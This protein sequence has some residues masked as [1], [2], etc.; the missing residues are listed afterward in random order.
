M[1]QRI[2]R[3]IELLGLDIAVYYAGHHSGHVLT[4]EQGHADSHIWAD[5]INVGME[6]GA[7]D[8]A[9]LAEY[10]RGLADGG[11]ARSGHRTPT[12]VVEAPVHGTDEMNVR[13]N[14]WQFRQILGRGVHGVLLCQTESAGAVRAF[15]EACR[16]PIHL[17]GVDPALP[18]PLQRLQGAAPRPPG[19]QDGRPLLGVGT[20][21]HGSEGTAAPI[22][23]LSNEDYLQRC[24]PWPL[25]PQGELMLGVKLESPEGVAR[26]DEILAVPGLAFAELGPGDLSLSLGYLR[27]PMQ[28]YPPEMVAARERVFAA[29]RRNGIAFLESCRP[30]NVAARIDEGVRVIAGQSEEAARIGRAHQ[31]RAMPA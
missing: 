9:G 28:A 1:P 13:H 17:N 8:L 26:A 5:Y 29:C 25:N 21:G 12:V 16:Y 7:F 3:A 27:P 10:M 6:H 23:G 31:K 11:P 4:Y 15:V 22:W 19:T 20:R 24:D 30:D 14:A 2:N 18:T